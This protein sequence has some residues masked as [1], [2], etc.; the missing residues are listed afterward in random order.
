[1]E[2][3]KNVKFVFYNSQHFQNSFGLSGIRPKQF[4]CSPGDIHH[5]T[6]KTDVQQ[7]PK[8]KLTSAHQIFITILI[9]NPNYQSF[10]C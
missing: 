7:D 9:F 1:M 3:E 8:I 2:K 6:L 5:V 4:L 10:V